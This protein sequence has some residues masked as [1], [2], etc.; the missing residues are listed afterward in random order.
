MCLEVAQWH[1][2]GGQTWPVPSASNTGLRSQPTA[3]CVGRS[4]KS[5]CAWPPVPPLFSSG[6]CRHK[7]VSL[8]AQER[9]P[10]QSRE[11]L[12]QDPPPRPGRLFVH[13]LASPH[14]RLAPWAGCGWGAGFELN[15]LPHRV[16]T[17]CSGPGQVPLGNHIKW[18]SYL[19]GKSVTL[20]CGL[21]PGTTAA[22]ICQPQHAFLGRPSRPCN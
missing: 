16:T 22:P 21:S 5:F 13:L 15:A 1:G 3:G 18:P 9:W 11:S 20:P 6:V 2:A 7:A 12:S 14:L 19:G 17:V 4:R 8:R 10:V